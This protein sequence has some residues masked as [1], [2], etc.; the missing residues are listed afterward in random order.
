[1]RLKRKLNRTRVLANQRKSDKEYSVNKQQKLGNRER[2]KHP[3]LA[4]DMVTFRLSDTR[5]NWSL[6]R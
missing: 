6:H 5:K 1:M 2:N 4:P 3:Y